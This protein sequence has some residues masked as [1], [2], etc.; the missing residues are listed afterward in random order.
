VVDGIERLQALVGRP[1][2]DELLREGPLAILAGTL[3][4]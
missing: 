4:D 3:E 1:E 2:A